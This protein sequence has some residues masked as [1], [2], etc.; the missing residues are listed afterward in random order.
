VT[1]TFLLAALVLHTQI[2]KVA[3]LPAVTCDVD[4]DCANTHSCGVFRG[5][6]EWVGMGL[7]PALEVALGSSVGLGDAVLDGDGVALPDDD[8]VGEAAAVTLGLPVTNAAASTALPGAEP[9]VVL[10]LATGGTAACAAQQGPK[11][12]KPMMVYPVAARNATRLAISIVTGASSSC[13]IPWQFRGNWLPD[14]YVS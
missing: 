3:K 7:G 2:T 1:E 6:V 11:M 8:G 12:L 10:T 13:E 9:Q 5:E 4:S 14:A